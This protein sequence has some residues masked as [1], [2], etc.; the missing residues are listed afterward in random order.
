MSENCEERL[1]ALEERVEELESRPQL[2]GDPNDFA[3]LRVEKDGREF[4]LGKV[5]KNKLGEQHEIVL[6]IKDRLDALENGDVEAEDLLDKVDTDTLPPIHQLY[7]TVESGNGDAMEKNQRRAAKVWPHFREYADKNYGGLSL[8]STKLADIF[9]RELHGEVDDPH[10]QTLTRVMKHL[11]EFS[12]GLLEFQNQHN[13]NRVVADVNDWE[14]LMDQV[15][16]GMGETS[17]DDSVSPENGPDEATPSEQTEKQSIPTVGNG[18]VEVG[19][20]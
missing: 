12:N 5:I 8:T 14:D 3:S 1:N 9:E 11:E 18:G 13:P 15:K 2:A 7:L 16:E 6:E 4:P 20:K 17:A 10:S 19:R